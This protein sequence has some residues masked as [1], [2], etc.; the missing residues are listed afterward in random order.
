MHLVQINGGQLSQNLYYTIDPWPYNSD[1]DNNTDTQS[2][3]YE[4]SA[5]FINRDNENGS[6]RVLAAKIVCNDQHSAR[7]V[8]KAK[9]SINDKPCNDDLLVSQNLVFFTCGDLS[10]QSEDKYNGLKG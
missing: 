5:Y 6:W 7:I 4:Y 2:R 1:K 8:A 3:W 10:N 9:V